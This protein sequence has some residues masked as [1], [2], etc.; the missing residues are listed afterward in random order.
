MTIA[1]HTPEGDV[2][3][4]VRR[5]SPTDEELAA[6]IAVVSEAYVDEAEHAVAADD[7]VRSAWHVSARGLRAPLR[8]E[9]GWGRFG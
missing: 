6:L 9:L 4:D 7:P 2:T 3:I 1:D 8:R 5:G